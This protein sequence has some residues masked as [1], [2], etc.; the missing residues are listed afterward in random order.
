MKFSGIVKKHLGRGTSLGFPTAN[1]DPP[2]GLEDGIY[3]GTANGKPAL[4]FIGLAKTYNE[5]ERKAEIHILDFSGD[6]YGES[7]DVETIQKIRENKKFY[8]EQDLVEQIH[9]DVKV[10]RQFFEEY[11]ISN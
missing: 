2:T 9:E 11:N 6:L 1:I 10:A 4:V 5:T 8:S 7:L 3:V